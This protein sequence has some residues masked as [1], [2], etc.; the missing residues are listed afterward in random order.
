MTTFHPENTFSKQHT[1][2]GTH[3]FWLGKLVCALSQNK[4]YRVRIRDGKELMLMNDE[5]SER[6]KSNSN[7]TP[8]RQML[9]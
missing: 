5:S 2:P 4:R 6:G 1:K 9:L 7:K 8:S 3:A